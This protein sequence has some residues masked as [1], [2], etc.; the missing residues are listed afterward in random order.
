MLDPR[1]KLCWES[2]INPKSETF[3]NATQSAIKAGY[4]PDYAD[5]ITTVEWFLGKLRRLNMLSKAEKVLDEYLEMEDTEITENGMQKRNPALSKIKQDTAKFIAER[6]G[7]DEG[8]STKQTVDTNLSGQV[9]TII[10]WENYENTESD[11]TIQAET[12][13]GG[14]PQFG[15][16]VEDTGMPQALREDDG[17]AEPPAEGRIETEWS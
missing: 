3:G 5:Q 16:E 12:A 17:G 10:E 11:N 6:V 1:Q 2:Y 7:K 4:A 14:I 13:D 9:K 8:Y 15:Q